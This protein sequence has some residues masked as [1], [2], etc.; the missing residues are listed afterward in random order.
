MSSITKANSLM[1]SRI[2]RLLALVI[3][4]GIIINLSFILGVVTF[5]IE[6]DF[7]TALIFIA[8]ACPFFIATLLLAQ[9][10]KK[11]YGYKVYLDNTLKK[12]FLHSGLER[13]G[14]TIRIIQN[15]SYNFERFAANDEKRSLFFTRQKHIVANYE[16]QLKSHD[17]VIK[18]DNERD[19][20]HLLTCNIAEARK[21]FEGKIEDYTLMG[22]YYLLNSKQADKQLRALVCYENKLTLWQVE[23]ANKMEYSIE[24]L[25]LIKNLP[26]GWIEKLLLDY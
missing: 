9:E 7:F 1:P 18:F 19:L 15:I 26:S 22:F 20:L 6:R 16:T 12:L 14:N 13:K 3:S 5:F 24:E 8:S 10:T 4:F 25:P 17:L 11:E 23:L 2:K 21:N